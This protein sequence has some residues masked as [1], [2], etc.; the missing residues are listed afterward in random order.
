M[1]TIGAMSHCASGAAPAAPASTGAPV[2]GRVLL[3]FQRWLHQLGVGHAVA[4]GR[5]DRCRNERGGQ[6]TRAQGWRIGRAR[7]VEAS[8]L[9]PT[10]QQWCRSVGHAADRRGCVSPAAQA[11]AA[12]ARSDE[13]MTL[14][15]APTEIDEQDELVEAPA[16]EE[17][18]SAGS[19]VKTH[20]WRRGAAFALVV[21]RLHWCSCWR[22]SPDRSSASGSAPASTTWRRTSSNRDRAWRRARRWASCRYRG[23]ASTSSWSRGILRSCCGAHRVIASAV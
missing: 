19:T 17:Q 7:R 21:A 6:R 4:V 22:S 1:K 3:G 9:A 14:A 18:P 15:G 10:R 5:D 13:R 8:A 16:P 2:V 20:R 12:L 11:G 23:S